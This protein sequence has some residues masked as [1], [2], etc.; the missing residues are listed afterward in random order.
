MTSG[1][2]PQESMDR[3]LQAIEDYPRRVAELSA[4]VAEAATRTVTGEAGDGQVVATLTAGGEIQSVRVTE[5]ALRNVDN[6]TLADLV[7]TAVNAGLDAADA[8]L[9]VRVDDGGADAAQEQ[10][11]AQYERQMDDLLGRLEAI[12]RGL[13]RF[14]G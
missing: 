14:D 10:A 3:L 2:D 1:P 11:L 7:T 12:D 13:D 5:R 4:Q 9:A 6:R 8:A